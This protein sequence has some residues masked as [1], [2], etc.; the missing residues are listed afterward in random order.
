MGTGELSWPSASFQVRRG[1]QLLLR[2]TTALNVFKFAASPIKHHTAVVFFFS[3]FLPP[4]LSSATH[5][6]RR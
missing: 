2:V 1:R 5:R 4:S 6:Y 3:L